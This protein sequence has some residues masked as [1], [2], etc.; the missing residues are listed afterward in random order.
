MGQRASQEAG[1][2]ANK[3]FQW[4]LLDTGTE[5]KFDPRSEDVCFS[6]NPSEL[7]IG[8]T[9]NKIHRFEL[10]YETELFV[11]KPTIN[12]IVKFGNTVV[13]TKQYELKH[14]QMNISKHFDARGSSL[15]WKDSES[16][17]FYFNCASSEMKFFDLK[18]CIEDRYKNCKTWI[19]ERLCINLGEGNA[20]T[21]I[22]SS[23][24]DVVSYDLCQ[25]CC[26]LCL[27]FSESVGLSAVPVYWG[28]QYNER[29]DCIS[30][31]NQQRGSLGL[32]PKFVILL[33]SWKD[34]SIIW[35]QGCHL[36]H[37]MSFNC[38]G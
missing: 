12:V 29:M 34:G 10:N 22:G 9:R 36:V 35:S 37:D 30:T 27:S 31:L 20:I 14:G 6:K 25:V 8:D 1:Q 4:Q 17:F 18:E 28:F 33:I 32:V 15:I 21:L 13:V 16:E 3:M 11:K 7:V 5:M 38:D 23:S 2:D 26:I 19:P 24:D